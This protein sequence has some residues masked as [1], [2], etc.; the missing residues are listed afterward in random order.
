MSIESEIVGHRLR[1]IR[2]S[3]NLTLQDV[4][5]LSKAEIS[6]ASLGSYERGYRSLSVEK[7][8]Q[9]SDFYQ[10]PLTYLLSGQQKVLDTD[11]TLLI[12]IRRVRHLISQ[13]PQ[14][15][16]RSLDIIIVYISAIISKRGDF[17]GEI[18]T[19]RSSD[20]V[21]LASIIGEDSLTNTLES[22][23]L[24]FATK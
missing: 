8:R 20:R 21:M 22:N 4:Q 16:S 12:D 18:L 1:S 2:R 11:A 9:I 5:R 7:A 6:A 15:Q 14:R 3:R 19:L 23:K 24:V 10:V 13:Q 17:N